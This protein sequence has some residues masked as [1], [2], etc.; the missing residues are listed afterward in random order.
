[1]TDDELNE[2]I[3]AIASGDVLNDSAYAEEYA[4]IHGL[5]P[6]TVRSTM[7][8]LRSKYGLEKRRS[9]GGAG[10]GAPPDELPYEVR[11]LLDR[12]AIAVEERLLGIQSRDLGS[13]FTSLLEDDA[14]TGALVAAVAIVRYERDPEFQEAVDRLRPYAQEIFSQLSPRRG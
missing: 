3:A 5:N 1:M 12:Q 11:E 4:S 14:V 8:R 2:L 9:E 7:S 6:A 13:G 10:V